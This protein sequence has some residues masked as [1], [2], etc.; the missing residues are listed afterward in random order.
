VVQERRRR[1]NVGKCGLQEGTGGNGLP[2][3]RRSEEGREEDYT[4][5]A[6]VCCIS[7]K[8]E[9]DRNDSYQGRACNVSEKKKRKRKYGEAV[10]RGSR[11]NGRN[12]RVHL[13]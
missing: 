3:A 4:V 8:D 13:V 9:A 10:G 6:R 1:R 11:S 2:V 12:Q 5:E 7:D